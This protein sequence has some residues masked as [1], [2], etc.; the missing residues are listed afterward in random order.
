MG[1]VT[2]I[3]DDG[4]I[5]PAPSVLKPQR[6]QPAAMATIP[7]QE[8]A[9]SA[10]DDS[11]APEEYL[12]NGVPRLTLRKLRRGHYP[13]QDRLDLHGLDTEGALSLLLKF[14]HQ[15][16]QRRMRCV[17]IIHGKGLH[18]QSGKGILRSRVRHWLARRAEVMA[19][20]EAPSA[21]GGSGAVLLLLKQASSPER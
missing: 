5:A 11:A 14:L 6:R 8:L 10:A 19:Y 13:L 9:V 4:R 3:R 20:C 15:A 1:G 12:A 21:L 2:P 7:D 17:L 18:T 16:S